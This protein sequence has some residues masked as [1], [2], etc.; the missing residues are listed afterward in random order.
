MRLAEWEKSPE[1]ARRSCRHRCQKSCERPSGTPTLPE[2]DRTL[3]NGIAPS[4]PEWKKLN[5]QVAGSC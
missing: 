4:T 2:Q 1:A 3:R 5:Q